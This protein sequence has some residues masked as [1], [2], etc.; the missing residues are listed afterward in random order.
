MS[1]VFME[2]SLVVLMVVTL[3][4]VRR[5]LYNVESIIAFSSVQMNDPLSEV[6]RLLQPTPVLEAHQRRRSLGCPLL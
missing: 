2:I 6:I 3:A 4:T 1:A 5:T